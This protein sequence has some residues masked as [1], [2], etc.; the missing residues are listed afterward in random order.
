MTLTPNYLPPT[1]VGTID[2][3]GAYLQQEFHRL[4]MVR[5]IQ[6]PE[7]QYAEAEV[8]RVFRDAADVALL[9][10][11]RASGQM[12]NY[13]LDLMFPY[14]AGMLAERPFVGAP[15][16]LSTLRP[17]QYDA[18]LPWNPPDVRDFLRANLWGVTVPGLPY[19]NRGSSRHPERCLT[20]L[21]YKWDAADRDRIYAA[22]HSPARRLTHL[23]LSW[24][25]ARDDGG[26][27]I[28][29][30]VALCREVKAAGLWVGVL[31][32][33][34]GR[35]QGNDI[36]GD[37][38]CQTPDEWKARL[39]PIVDA[40]LSANVVDELSVW[41]WD[42]FNIPGDPTIETFRWIGE[43][44]HAAGATFWPHFSTEVGAWFRDKEPRGRFGFWDDL[45]DR[46]DGLNYQADSNWDVPQLQGHLMDWL[47]QFA[48]QGNRRK[49]RIFELSASLQFA[50]AT[51]DEWDE[52]R[53][54][55]MGYLAC[56]TGG[57][58][59]GGTS[60]RVWGYGNGA[61]RP[62]GSPV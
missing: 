12:V 17:Y 28:G 2:E 18:A 21:L 25:D 56:C 1:Q 35:A 57:P 45:G 5:T 11:G 32:G 41:E 36:D 47:N 59:S 24:P 38:F 23:Y 46:V 7:F 60:A 13:V 58:K 48:Q 37:P 31:L 8:R 29:S 15:Q 62:D 30:F 50:D 26:L 54:N 27:S 42:L 34:K 44:A 49:L 9:E 55:T 51:A 53:G 6:P 52:W 22:H 40:L 61:A 19:V 10:T 14:V 16:A 39:Q 3:A 33:A 20:Y 4:G 43:R